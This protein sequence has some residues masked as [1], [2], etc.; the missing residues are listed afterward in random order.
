MHLSLSGGG[1]LGA[2][3]LG[4]VDFFRI[5]APQVIEG[6][7]IGTSVGAL[8][9]ATTCCSVCFD[10]LIIEL[11]KL[12]A[13]VRSIHPWVVN[14]Q[15]KL[16]DAIRRSLDSILPSN[17]HSICSG[18]LHVSLTKWRETEHHM[19]SHFETREELIEVLVCSSFIP[20]LS[21]LIPPKYKG[22]YYWDGGVTQNCPAVDEATIR[23]CPLT[24]CAEICPPSDHK[25]EQSNSWFNKI[26]TK[27]DVTVSGMSF[28][29][30]WSNVRKFVYSLMPRDPS[31]FCELY[32]SG[33]TAALQFSRSQMSI[34]IDEADATS[35][36][37]KTIDNI[38]K[39]AHSF[40]YANSEKDSSNGYVKVALKVWAMPMTI[41]WHMTPFSSKLSVPDESMNQLS[42]KHE[43]ECWQCDL[44]NRYNQM[45]LNLIKASKDMMSK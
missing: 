17:A 4:V 20:I 8:V 19:V 13:G 23:V 37:Q 42:R 12:T 44:F 1:F 34:K 27:Q 26:W 41:C 22:E 36:M 6:P 11:M 25:P 14:P 15:F 10:R 39:L 45:M 18:R 33:Y 29:F 21:G 32:E 9:A 30:C 2:F 7:I 31:S 24:S 28:K 43:S 35:R 38:A 16:S 5:Y 40:N 3:H